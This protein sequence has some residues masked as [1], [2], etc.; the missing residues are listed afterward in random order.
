M[1]NSTY[2]VTAEQLQFFKE[3]GYLLIRNYFNP[4]ETTLLQ[5][6]SQEVHDLPRTP[7]VPWMPYEV[8]FDQTDNKLKKIDRL[9]GNNT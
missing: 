1:D 8:S 7:D 6:W 2:T 3:K 4:A 5:Q 9:T